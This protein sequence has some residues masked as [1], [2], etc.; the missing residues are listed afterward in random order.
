VVK[1][2]TATYLYGSSICKERESHDALIRVQCL[3][4]PN[5]HEL[6]APSTSHE[7]IEWCVCM[8]RTQRVHYIREM[9]CSYLY[10]DSLI[11]VR[12]ASPIRLT[13]PCA[14]RITHS[15][16]MTHSYVCTMTHPYIYHDSHIRVH[17]ASLIHAQH[18]THMCAQ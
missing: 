11:C 5:L 1:P 14:Q 8:S 16:T 10:N 18:L 12:N 9:P 3:V 15:C 6:I 7:L 4:F 17:N 13:Q 2:R